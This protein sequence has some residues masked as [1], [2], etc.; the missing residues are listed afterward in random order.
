MPENVFDGNAFLKLATCRE[1][2]LL[3]NPRDT[4]IGRAV[5]IYGEF[6]FAETLFFDQ[7][8]RPGDVAL[9]LGANIGAHTV[10]MA[11]LVGPSGRVLAFEPQRTVFQMMCANMA[12]NSIGNV[13]A[14][15]AAVG[16]RQGHILVPRLDPESA[17]NFG[18]FSLIGSDSGDSVPL[19]AIDDLQL[20]ECRLMKLDIEGMEFEALK[21]AESTISKLK[22]V[23]YVENENRD[24]VADVIS[25]ILSHG[26][27]AWWHLPA[28]FNPNNFR[29]VQDNYFCSEASPNMIC[30]HGSERCTVLD[31]EPVL[32][33]EDSWARVARA[34]DKTGVPVH[35]RPHPRV[36]PA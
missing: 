25:F 28:Y 30:I 7:I 13:D 20:T 27:S 23:L 19:V 11:R 17:R 35:L 9:D 29:G 2:V 26:Y 6:S 18:A 16:A 33:P 32:G 12:L 4:Y 1:G 24:G 5:D 10:H 21:G 31:A 36:V 34:A 8:L 15:W 14:H 3:C 22:P